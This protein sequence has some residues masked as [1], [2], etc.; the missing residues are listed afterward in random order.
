MSADPTEFAEQP[1]GAIPQKRRRG[2][3]RKM[4]ST[5]TTLSGRSADRRATLRNNNDFESSVII[6]ADFD[7]LFC[8]VAVL[9]RCAN[10][11]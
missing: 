2:R 9:L 3:P 7:E 6:D 10:Q 5:L 1:G 4:P 8:T 11:A